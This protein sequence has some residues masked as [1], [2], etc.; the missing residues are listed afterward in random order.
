M[1]FNK[2]SRLSF[3]CFGYAFLYIPL[4]LVVVF[5]FNS[6]R[7]IYAWESFSLKWYMEL[8]ATPSIF[9]SVL[10]SLKIATISATFAMVIGAVAAVGLTKAHAFKHRRLFETMINLPLIIP[11]VVT[12]L[13][14]LLFF[15]SVNNLF[16]IEVAYGISTISIAHITIGIAYVV[17]VVRSRLQELDFALEE[18]AMDLGAKPFGVFVSITL[19][20]IFPACLAGWFLSFALS[21]DDVVIASFVSSPDSTTLPMIIF[22]TIRTGGMSPKINALAALMLAITTVGVLIV[23][24]VAYRRVKK[25]NRLGGLNKY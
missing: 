23:A 6:A 20:L 19:P 13:S 11:E 12:G 1:R 2:V 21:F 8:I 10:N 14:L 24:F 7:N 5:S 18:A 9:Q 17:V 4:A 22:S 3:L 25:Q 16:G 15:V